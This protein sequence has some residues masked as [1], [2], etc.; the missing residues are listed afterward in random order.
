MKRMAESREKF[1][2]PAQG[3]RPSEEMMTALRKNREETSRKL[4]EVLSKE[5]MAEYEKMMSER[6]G[7]MGGPFGGGR[8][9]ER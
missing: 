8:G 2:P 6:G 1:G 5:Q 7:R 3:E 4:S 9:K